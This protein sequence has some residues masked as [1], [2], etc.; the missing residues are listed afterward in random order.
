MIGTIGDQP[1]AYKKP[2]AADAGRCGDA[3]G[4][5]AKAPVTAACEGGAEKRAGPFGLRDCAWSRS[6]E[7]FC[8]ASDIRCAKRCWIGCRDCAGWDGRCACLGDPYGS[9]CPTS[10]N[11]C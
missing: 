5:Q 4:Q 2:Y 9:D 6:S 10:A 11:W 1:A 3:V 8:G 7:H